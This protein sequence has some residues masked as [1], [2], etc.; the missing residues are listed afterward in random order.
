MTRLL[1]IF[2]ELLDYTEYTSLMVYFTLA[3]VV[4]TFLVFKFIKKYK[5]AK[6]MPGLAMLL[7][8]L[9][10]LFRMDM[11]TEQFLQDKNMILFITGT[12]TG[13]AT[14]LFGL[15]LGVIVKDKKDKKEKKIRRKPKEE[16]DIEGNKVDI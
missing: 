16:P 10:S 15:I 9:F 7:F 8:G 14:M 5:W 12:T 3:G 2:K 6:Y 4:V 13:I 1:E 11:S